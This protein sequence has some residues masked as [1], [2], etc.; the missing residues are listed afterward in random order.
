MYENT[1]YEFAILYWKASPLEWNIFFYIV[2]WGSRFL[3][4]SSDFHNAARR[5]LR[6]SYWLDFFSV[7]LTFVLKIFLFL[8]LPQQR[9]PDRP[10][11][12]GSPVL[13]LLCA[14][15][16]RRLEAF[17]FFAVRGIDCLN[18]RLDLNSVIK[19]YFL[20]NGTIQ[21]FSGKLL[22]FDLLRK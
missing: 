12:P 16:T 10:I 13:V 14:Q 21:I 15:R 18:K 2:C 9:L 8:F 22:A 6:S 4:P 5:V 11:L 3:F 20:K 7:T 1:Q 17:V 19:I